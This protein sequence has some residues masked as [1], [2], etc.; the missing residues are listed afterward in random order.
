MNEISKDDIQFLIRWANNHPDMF[1]VLVIQ[2]AY[3]LFL[4]RYEFMSEQM[5][6]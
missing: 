1:C 2:F 5:E 4:K 6:L 3:K